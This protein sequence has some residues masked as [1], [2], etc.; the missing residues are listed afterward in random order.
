M[1][2]ILTA[3]ATADAIAATEGNPLAEWVARE[4][5][6]PLVTPATMAQVLRGIETDPDLTPRERPAYRRLADEAVMDLENRT[7]EILAN[8]TFGFQEA[9]VLAEI[10]EIPAGA[11][12]GE[13]DLVPAAIAVR[14]GHDLVV[15]EDADAW[16]AFADSIPEAIGKLRLKIF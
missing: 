14:R 7:E 11:P 3:S 4:G 9:R 8:A 2:Y 5:L 1:A 13:F 12:F 6:R 16:S 10:M 15:V